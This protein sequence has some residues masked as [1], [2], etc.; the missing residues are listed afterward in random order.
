MTRTVVSLVFNDFRNDIRVLKEAVSL[1]VLDFKV[2]VAAT[3]NGEL[4]RE[5]NVKGVRVERIGISGFN[6]LPLDLMIYWFKCCWRYR[7]QSIFHCNDLYALPIGVFIKKFINTASKVVYDCHEH[8]TEAHVYAGR[9]LLKRAAKLAE[10]HLIKYAD[11]VI[12]VSDSIADDYVR[13]YGIEKPRLILNCPE[14]RKYERQDLFRTEYQ[15]PP[16]DRILL[17]QGEYR[18]GRGLEIIIDCFN[19]LPEDL[20]IVL[21][22]LG[23]GPYGSHLRSIVTNRRKIF[24]HEPVGMDRYMDY[25]AS[26]DIG[27]HLMESTC[28]NHEYALPNK[29]FEYAMAGLPVIVSNLKEMRR[30]V[31]SNR[32]GYVLRANRAED[33][34]E[35]LRKVNDADLEEFRPGLDKVASV[36]NWEAQEKT[37]VQIYRDL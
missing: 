12:T 29:L 13:L 36:Y 28:L 24:I 34:L 22:L 3:S 15:I 33:L 10:R 31:E 26:A 8:E 20:R 37:L 9:A 30:V 4:P 25:V 14:Y 32:I 16:Q 19:R 18:K 2:I 6:L 21:V 11:R 27:I 7:R 5:E 17:Y 35:V 23:Y 1:S